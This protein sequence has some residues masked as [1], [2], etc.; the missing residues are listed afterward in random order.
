MRIADAQQRN[1]HFIAVPDT[2][3]AIF[4]ALPLTPINSDQ[5]IML[6]E[7]NV[8][9]GDYP[10][11]KELGMTPRPLDAFLEKWRVRYRQHGRF[12]KSEAGAA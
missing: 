7:G 12:G 6:K 10:G 1:R 4:A 3:S 5:W 8:T 11:F 2:F 9:S